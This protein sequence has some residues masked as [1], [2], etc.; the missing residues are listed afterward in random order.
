MVE[1]VRLGVA[2][3][4]GNA[5]HTS[6]VAELVDLVGLSVNIF[7]PYSPQSSY[8]S[9]TPSFAACSL[10]PTRS[11]YPGRAIRQSHHARALR[12]GAPPRPTNT[13]TSSGENPCLRILFK[14]TCLRKG[15]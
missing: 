6:I 4:A 10:P 15:T 8:A 9:S 14:T 1:G 5:G 11:R 3:H 7:P 13:S 12:I 2:V